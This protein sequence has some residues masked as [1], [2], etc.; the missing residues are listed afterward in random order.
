L[1]NQPLL[2]SRR[3]NGKAPDVLIYSKKGVDKNIPLF[4]VKRKVFIEES[5]EKIKNYKFIM[6]EGGE[7][8]YNELKDF[9]DWKVFLISNTLKN[10]VNFR[11]DDKI[12]ILHINE[13]EDD[14]ILF[15]K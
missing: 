7:K 11:S 4:E 6:V 15:G 12:D 5:L 3:V 1:I 14:L 9:V 13:L 2:D 10:R 8:L